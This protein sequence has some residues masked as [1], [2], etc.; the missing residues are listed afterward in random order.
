MQGD[1]IE[2]WK[3]IKGYEGLYQISNLGNVRNRHGKLLKPFKKD[4]YGHALVGLS[5]NNK[6]TKFQIHRLVALHFIPNP[7]NKSEVCHIDNTLDENGLLDNSVSNL[8]WGTHKENC[9]FE[10]TRKRQSEN[11]ADFSG[12]NNP[13]YGNHY[14]EENK[15]KLMKERGKQVLQWE[16]GSVIAF[17]DSLKEAGRKTGICWVNFRNVCDGQYKH[18]GGYEWTF[19]CKPYDVEKVVAEL[20]EE[21][22]RLKKLKNNCIALSDH[23]VCDI[24]NKAYNFAI[25]CVRNGGKE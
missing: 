14:S 12:E 5:E 19:A 24:E 17:Y 3:V 23:E 7:D 9:E 21:N 4:K 16:N 8:M 10:N 1:L 20:E 13:N 6:S 15:A 22:Q 18:A 25:K 11:H 2:E